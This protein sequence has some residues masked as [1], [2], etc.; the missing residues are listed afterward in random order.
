MNLKLF[1]NEARNQ[2]EFHFNGFKPKIEYINKNGRIYLTHTEVSKELGGKGIGT[3]LVKA[4]LDDIEKQGLSLV[5][6]CPFVAAYI[7]KHPERKNIL[8]KNIKI[9]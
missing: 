6:L 5:P 9:E 7:K 1:N 3:A 2:Y 4:V 8:Y